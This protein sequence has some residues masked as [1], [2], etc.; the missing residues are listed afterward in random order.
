MQELE[1]KMA[2]MYRKVPEQYRLILPGR[3]ERAECSCPATPLRS[4]VNSYV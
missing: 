3:E 4:K 1:D 2:E